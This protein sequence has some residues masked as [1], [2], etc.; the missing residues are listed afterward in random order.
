MDIMYLIKT[1]SGVIGEPLSFPRLSETMSSL[2]QYS[3]LIL[4]GN[5]KAAE[6]RDKRVGKNID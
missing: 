5:K 4:Y 1:L 2:N 6:E 3:L